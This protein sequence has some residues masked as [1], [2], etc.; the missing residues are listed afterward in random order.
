MKGKLLIY[1]VA[2]VILLLVNVIAVMRVHAYYSKQQAIARLF[3][4]ID[5]Q[6]NNVDQFG[7]SAAPFASDAIQTGTETRDG[8]VANLK[9]FLRKYN[10][11]LYDEA[12]HIVTVSDKYKFDYRL[13]VA[14]AMQESNAC[15]SI[16][17]GSYNCW[18]WGIYGNQVVRFNS[19]TEAIDT[20]A[21]G[22]KSEYLDKGLVTA[23]AIMAKY[24][25][26]SNG[27]WAFGVN[28]FL[29]ALQ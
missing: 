28:H 13:L 20:V 6:K 5:Y 22:I 2:F 15:R 7:N 23:S 17:E 14:I 27:S 3:N 8:R 4:E 1:S 19:Y 25:P 10:S 18:G 11:P 26:S 9:S 21:E 16:P 24:T 12:E 29:Q